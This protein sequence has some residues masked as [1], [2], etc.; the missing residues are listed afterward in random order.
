MPESVALSD[1]RPP[2]GAIQRLVDGHPA[3]RNWSAEQL[4]ELEGHCR[5]QRAGAGDLLLQRGALDPF[6]MFLLEGQLLLSDGTTSRRVLAGSSDAGFPVARLRPA[7]FDVAAEEPSRLLLV[8]RSVLARLTEQGS[9]PAQRVRFDLFA[10]PV[11]GSWQDHPLVPELYRAT[12][13]G[14]LRLPVI[15]N[16]AL[17]IRRAL[18]NDDYEIRD[19]ARILAADPVVSAR[20]LQLANSPVFKGMSSCDSIQSAVVRLGINK[21]RNLVLALS[22]SQLFQTDE[23][24][25]RKQL[26]AVWRHLLVVGS[27]T[28]VMARRVDALDSDLALL[29]G[30]L[31]EIGKIPILQAAARYPDLMTNAGLLQDIL[32]ALG[33]QI[34]M[35]TLKEWQIAEPVV[36]A[37][38]RQHQWSYEHDGGADYSDLLIVAH[39]Y[40]H[41]SSPDQPPLPPLTEVPAFSR[42]TGT[43]LTA[44]QSLEILREADAESRALKQLLTG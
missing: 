5:L 3:F 21:V 29:V 10:P 35:A 16:V 24:L 8:E 13:N 33:P 38:E 27:L 42:I 39:V 14:Q 30:L 22:S 37:A 36:Q 28:A 17:K 6:V 2:T 26:S 41:K 23:P 31:H 18:E 20:L 11:S 32:S 25:I 4:A 43:E 34:S 40:G 12:E 7:L 9:R 15:P 1:V 19:I 44:Q